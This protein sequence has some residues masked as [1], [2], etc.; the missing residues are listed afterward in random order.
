MLQIQM[1]GKTA[2]CGINLQKTRQSQESSKLT[3]RH[4]AS[5]FK[6]IHSHFQTGEIRTLSELTGE[7]SGQLI[8]LLVEVH[9]S[10]PTFS[11]K[12]DTVVLLHLL[13]EKEERLEFLPLPK[14]VYISSSKPLGSTIF[15]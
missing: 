11:R 9:D 8:Q 5:R 10:S 1:K 4:A 13:G 2:N 12:S 6:N 15:K 14:I 7:A 3:R